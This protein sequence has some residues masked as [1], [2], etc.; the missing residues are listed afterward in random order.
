MEELDLRIQKLT[1]NYEFIKDL[2]DQC[3]A[4]YGFDLK[5]AGQGVRY[6]NFRQK[7]AKP[8]REQMIEG[9]ETLI[10]DAE[11][12]FLNCVADECPEFLN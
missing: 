6:L 7:R 11:R 10:E 8:I 12:T 1:E 9:V 3:N 4:H 5:D 2:Y